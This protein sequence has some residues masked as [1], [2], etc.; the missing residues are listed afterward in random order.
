MLYPKTLR[1]NYSSRFSKTTLTSHT[2]AWEICNHTYWQF[3]SE[4]ANLLGRLVD[5][6]CRRILRHIFICSTRTEPICDLY[7]KH[8]KRSYSLWESNQ[9]FDVWRNQQF[10]WG[11]HAQIHGHDLWHHACKTIDELFSLPK[12]NPWYDFPTPFNGAARRNHLRRSIA[13]ITN[14]TRVS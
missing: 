12:F 11:Q 1:I 5:P 10:E 6:Y 8:I 2:I 7:C 4:Y 3:L 13:S 14:R 9:Q